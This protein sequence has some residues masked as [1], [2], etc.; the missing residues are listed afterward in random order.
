MKRYFR[1]NS[2]TLFFLVLFLATLVGQAYA[3]HADFNNQLVADGLEPIGLGRYVTSSQYAVD[4]VENWQ[5]EYLQFLLFTIATVW[6]VQRGSPESSAPDKI[7][8]ESDKEQMVRQYAKKDS[9]P[10]AKAGGLRLFVFSWSFTIVMGAIFILSWLAQSITGQS[11]YNT[12]RLA[13]L[14]APLGWGD[15]LQSADFWNRS[16]QNWQSEFLAVASMVVLSIFLRHRGS[17]QS[18]PVG[19]PHAATGVEG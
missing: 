19:A 11:A 17:S 15:Y 4:V 8:H 6:L 10:W 16:L 12:E 18:K 9:P 5:S 1:D 7:G 13:Q 3:G 14:Q 2:L